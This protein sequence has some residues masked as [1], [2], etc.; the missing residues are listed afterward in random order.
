MA[1]VCPESGVDGNHHSDS[2]ESQTSKLGAS[3]QEF[4][5]HLRLPMTHPRCNGY[6]QHGNANG[7]DDFEAHR[8]DLI[9]LMSRIGM[10]SIFEL[11]TKLINGVEFSSN[12]TS[13][14]AIVDTNA[15]PGTILEPSQLLTTQFLHESYQHLLLQ[16]A[17]SPTIGPMLSLLELHDHSISQLLFT[18]ATMLAPTIAMMELCLRFFAVFLCPL[19]LCCM[20]QWEIQLAI[21]KSNPVTDSKVASLKSTAKMYYTAIGSR[22][23]DTAKS[24]TVL[25]I[26]IVGL[27]SSAVLFT[28]TLYVFEYGRRFGMSL[29]ILSSIM[30]VRCAAIQEMKHA[31]G[32]ERKSKGGISRKIFIFRCVIILLIASTT[33]LCWRSD[34]GHAMEASIK[35]F[36]PQ[37]LITAYQHV[38]HDANFVLQPK[39]RIPND[40]GIDL[41]TINEGLYH[42]SSN[43]LISSIVSNWPNSSRTYNIANGA[44][45]Y[46]VTGDQRTGV[47]FLVN[48]VEEQEYIR[49]WQQNKFDGEY[50]A[51]DIAFP[52]SNDIKEDHSNDENVHGKGGL[53]VHDLT[54]PVYLVLHG[55][56]GGS[57]EEYVKDFTKRRRSEGSTVI[58][59]IARGMMDTTLVG[60]NVFHGARTGD[61]DA[62]ARALRRGL[63]SLAEAHHIRPEQRQI[64]AG[65]GYSMGE[66]GY[67]VVC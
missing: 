46:L 51:L 8:D 22:E 41:P 24:T 54:K 20:I 10:G 29:F 19:C 49:V 33:V 35:R 16:Q 65:V 43:T 48:Q 23:N 4:L 7:S 63:T 44:T 67:C 60:W 57:H 6:A 45:P 9:D 14:T 59:M 32:N 18:A 21:S 5:D 12:T 2:M 30:A 15:A 25:A 50:S 17:S 11:P 40:P 36:A 58:V 28:D 38:K 27:A 62:A 31:E 66:W 1:S 39:P 37:L 52:Y 26:C 42:S 3:A 64:L 55:L 34:G 47:Q 61:V 56:N 13:T 53:F